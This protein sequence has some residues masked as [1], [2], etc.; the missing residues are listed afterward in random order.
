MFKG[1]EATAV[2]VGCFAHARRYFFEAL[3]TD[4]RAAVAIHYIGQLYGVEHD[5]AE[6]GLDP[7]GRL[8]LRREKSKP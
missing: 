3:E 7:E 8:A 6:N 2:E 5:A 4:R 1:P